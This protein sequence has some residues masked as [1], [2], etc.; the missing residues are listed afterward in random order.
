MASRIFPRRK[1]L[2]IAS[3]G[4]WNAAAP[5]PHRVSYGRSYFEAMCA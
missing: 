1:G 4:A 2:G 5:V 3:S